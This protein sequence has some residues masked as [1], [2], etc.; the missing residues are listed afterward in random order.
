M[1]LP[2]NLYTWVHHALYE[3]FFICLI[4]VDWFWK[5]NMFIT[6]MKTLANIVIVV[7]AFSPSMIGF[8]VCAKSV[9]VR[10]LAR[11]RWPRHLFFLAYQ[12]HFA[13]LTCSIMLY[14]S[15]INLNK[16]MFIYNCS[17]IS[18]ILSLLRTLVYNF[19]FCFKVFPISW[20]PEVFPKQMCCHD[21]CF[22]RNC[23]N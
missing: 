6:N 5:A 1:N 13:T 22:L 23:D 2:R 9:T 12:C 7:F 19:F 14:S 15:Y 10:L 20:G 17:N 8:Q 11:K 18:C 3:L 16:W 4:Y 21:V